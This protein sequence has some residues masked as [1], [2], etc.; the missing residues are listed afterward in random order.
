MSDDK[1]SSGKPAYSSLSIIPERRLLDRE[2]ISS[3]PNQFWSNA[4]TSARDID[5]AS[6]SAPG[7]PP[8]PLLKPSGISRTQ[9]M[10]I[11]QAF[12][13]PGFPSYVSGQ[14]GLVVDRVL[15][16]GGGK[17]WWSAMSGRARVG[18]MSSD[19]KTLGL[20]KVVRDP[21][22]FS[23]GANT[24]ILVGRATQFRNKMQ[25]E[26]SKGIR[27]G[28]SAASQLRRKVRGSEVRAELSLNQYR[29]ESESVQIGS[30]YSVTP[31]AATLD[32]GTG[33]TNPSALQYRMGLYHAHAPYPD[34]KSTTD[35]EYWSGHST[36]LDAQGAL[37]AHGSLTLWKGRS[38]TSRWDQLPKDS[39]GAESSGSS[40][41]TDE[42]SKVEQS[43]QRV[44]GELQDLTAWVTSGNFASRIAGRGSKGE[45]APVSIAFL[46]RVL[47]VEVGG[48]LGVLAHRP[49]IKAGEEKA[50]AEVMI[51]PDESKEGG[52]RSRSA[53]AMALL[54][55]GADSLRK[56]TS[57]RPF[58][59]IAASLQMGCFR[60]CIL[61]FT[62]VVAK[63]DFALPDSRK[64]GSG[65]HPAFTLGKAGT[66]NA[67]TLS[68]SQQIYGPLRAC[69]DF[70]YS[71]DSPEPP[72][73]FTGFKQPKQQAQALVTHAK[74]MK[75]SLQ[76]SVYGLDLGVPGTS[77]FARVFAWYS[78][79]RKEGMLEVRLF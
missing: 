6:I 42:T 28:L 49:V 22:N 67:L 14:G 24:K 48:L 16:K 33:S 31:L 70:R 59:T 71:M 7:Q 77:G 29:L 57:V 65:V 46:A 17:K 63:M 20:G 43:I 23:F 15:L 41:G 69:A 60:R 5:G 74:S 37:A 35:I 26:P 32:I 10:L 30:V 51:Q 58:G 55:R 11:P 2:I 25:F 62:R 76:D 53:K 47:F 79:T 21:S 18:K 39:V 56:D 54:D 73:E 61:D 52:A 27:R 3:V 44:R 68:C 8:L 12:G 45:E 64:G 1:S 38:R 78:P 36:S 40:T 72:P 13:V 66:W 34:K 19:R 50:A 4:F 75:P 9:L